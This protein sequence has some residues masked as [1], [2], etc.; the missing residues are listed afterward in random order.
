MLWCSDRSLRL[1]VCVPDIAL[2]CR[3]IIRGR[4][5]SR[6]RDASDDISCIDEAE[7]DAIGYGEAVV[8]IEADIT[9]GEGLALGL[10]FAAPRTAPSN[11]KRSGTTPVVS[12]LEVVVAERC[13][14]SIDGQ[15]RSKCVQVLGLQK[16]VLERNRGAG[17]SCRDM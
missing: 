13:S 8:T 17:Q 9:P 2:D 14:V 5:G 7:D 6:P 16:G 4:L 10:L 3:L 15:M 12:M 11:S 1:L